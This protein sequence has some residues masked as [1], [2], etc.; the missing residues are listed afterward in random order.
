MGL[1]KRAVA[2]DWLGPFAHAWTTLGSLG[3]DR[4][5]TVDPRG[6]VTPQS[7]GWSLDWWIGADDRWHFPSGDQGVRQRLVEN[8]PVVETAMR[9]PGG[10][11]VHRAYG[12][13]GPGGGFVVVEVENRSPVPFAVAL[14]IRPY[15]PEGPA[16]VKRI[17]FSDDAATVD[18]RAA[19]LFQKRPARMA[20][21]TLE[22]GDVAEV[23]TS[24]A[25]GDRLPDPLRCRHGLAGA[26]FVFPLAHTA[27]LRVALPLRPGRRGHAQLP[28]R[29]PSSADVARGWRAQSS[30]G[31]RLELPPGRIADAVEANRRFLLLFDEDPDPNPG[32]GDGPL[33]VA[34]GDLAVGDR[35]AL[36]RLQSFLDEA[37]DTFTWPPGHD[38]R[39]ASDLVSFV[40][41][42]LAREAPDG[43][44]LVLCATLPEAWAGQPLEVHD[45]PTRYGT[46]SFAVRWHGERPALLWELERDDGVG[47]VR[48]SAPGLDPAWS[49]TEA[50]G[51]ALLQAHAGPSMT[52]ESFS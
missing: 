18:G 14:A 9:V 36:D 17:G 50:R 37:T 10:D 22:L 40:Q 1:G 47:P 31:M 45:V 5:G 11:A 25:A 41:A 48:L 42:M 12:V 30:Q 28:P 7:G 39:A 13:P 4:R 29:L 26:A 19:V 38:R 34:F 16:V 3:S 8:T 43:D 24:G 44:G 2:A 23:V 27:T 20:G 49:S 51:E 15:N 21:S 52:Q 46:L 35:R 6:L 32:R 33:Q